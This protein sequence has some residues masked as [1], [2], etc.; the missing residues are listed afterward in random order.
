MPTPRMNQ[1][2]IDAVER[3][4]RAGLT[5]AQIA[6][7]LKVSTGAVA[8][9]KKMMGQVAEVDLARAREEN[10]VLRR[11]HRE[12]LKEIGVLRKELDLFTTAADLARHVKPVRIVLKGGSAKGE[13][14]AVISVS[15]LHFEEKV[16]RTAVNGVNEYNLDIARKRVRKLFTTGASL[17]DMCR[18]RSRIETIVV[19]L[20][21]DMIAGNI[22]D[23]L[24][25][26]NELTPAE[27][28]LAVF[29]EL[30]SGLDYL[31][32]ETKA[33]EIIVPCVCGNHGRFTKKRWSKQG[34]GMSFE[35]ILYGLL[36]RWF[37]ARKDKVVRFL[38]PEGDMAYIEVYGRT[39]RIMHGDNIRYGGGIGGV[40]IP[41]RKAIDVWN[42]YKRADYNY[43]GHWH[44]DFTGEDY[45]VNGSVV[46]FNEYSIRIK[47]RYQPASQAFELQHPKYGAT[48]RFPMIVQ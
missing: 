6:T 21:G 31:K 48:A 28:V 12:A 20:M 13:A 30:V 19:N 2:T 27:A 24:I 14:T 1:A 4:L 42:T 15:D 33:K 45:R 32:K 29:E 22:H 34:P 3:K 35:Y 10:T 36:A 23:E 16:E 18:S 11:K 7:K 43:L 8:K 25:A 44:S 47:A 26:T 46:G 5:Q 37:E 17:V 9:I 40:H 38:L 41:L 39:I